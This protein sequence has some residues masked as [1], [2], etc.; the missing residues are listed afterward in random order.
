MVK[1]IA[2]QIPATSK[3]TSLLVLGVFEN[4]FEDIMNELYGISK[5]IVEMVQRI[6][7]DK[8]HTGSFG[9]SCIVHCFTGPIQRIML[10]GLGEKKSLDKDKVRVLAGKACC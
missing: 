2:E 1:L 10:L 4:E 3:Q 5:T 6:V 9:S 7:K 8:E